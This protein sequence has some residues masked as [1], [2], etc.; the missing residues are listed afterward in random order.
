MSI[1]TRERERAIVVGVIF[2][3]QT[4]A[5]VDEYLDELELLA[6]TAGADVICRIYQEREKPDPA[7]F[8][9]RGKAEQ[10][11][12]IVGEE[13]IDV[14]IFDDDLSGVQIR[15]LEDV[16]NCKVIDRTTLILDIFASH[17]RTAP[18]KIQVELAQLEYLLPRLTG[19]W[20]HLSK[21]YGGIG[22]KGPGETQLETDRRLVKRKIAILRRKLSEIDNQRKIQRKGRRDIFRVALVGYTNAGKSTL[23]NA[24]ADANAY[25]EDK[26]FA[27]L[28]ATTR[29]VRLSPTRKIL[30]T[31]TV[32][33]IRKLPH[34]L[35]AS[36]KSTLDEVVEADI[37]IHVVDISAPNFREQIKVV[38]ETLEELNSLDK[39]T[40]LAF[41]KIDKLQDRS[42]IYSLANEYK[43]AVFISASRG[44]N[45]H[46]LKE[47]ISQMIDDHYVEITGKVEISNSKAISLI[48]KFGEVLDVKYDTDNYLTLKIKIEKR[49]LP[50]ISSY[51]F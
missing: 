50:K 16:I 17:A 51:I 20:R 13:K 23:L 25:V 35:I 8:I 10:I 14:V 30:L 34:H 12:K 22:T 7:F 46:T 41:N 18:A 5:Q 4:K 27:T 26:L 32:G 44:V 45:I 48:Y 47:K 49:H 24:L 29:V 39:P 38:E 19:K 15:N 2:P 9:G 43:D 33:F 1:Y 21:Q 11:A 37:L 3:H 36:F 6:D 42:L 40:I 31:D 28:D